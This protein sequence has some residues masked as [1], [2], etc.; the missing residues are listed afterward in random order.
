MGS[1]YYHDV[2]NLSPND[3]AAFETARTPAA[4]DYDDFKRDVVTQLAKR[5]DP[6]VTV[7]HKAIA[8]AARGSRRDADVVAAVQFRRYW[9]YKSFYDQRYTDGICFWTRDGAQIINYPKQHRANA[10]TKHQATNSWFKP[11]VRILKNMRNT[12]IDKGH[13]AAGVAPSYFLGGCSTTC[14]TTNSSGPTSTRSV[15]RS[16]GCWPATAIN[17]S[18]P[19][20]STCLKQM[21]RQRS[22]ITRCRRYSTVTRH[23]WPT[24][25]GS[26][27]RR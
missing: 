1:V 14:P 19:T 7:G 18:A 24:S 10:T 16:T 3:R 17:C 21:S 13:L 4:Y 22:L 6:D 27:A 20:S 9:S 11:C 8:V 2:E 12:M 25:P 26:S 5:F 23:E 15:G